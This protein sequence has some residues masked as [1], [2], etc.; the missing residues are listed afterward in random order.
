MSLPGFSAEYG[1]YESTHYYQ[2]SAPAERNIQ[3]SWQVSQPA[4][5]V[6]AW[7]GYCEQ[8]DIAGVV[9]PATCRKIC[10]TEGTECSV[11]CSTGSGGGSVPHCNPA[12]PQ[13]TPQNPNAN[14]VCCGSS[15]YIN[16]VLT[17][18]ESCTNLLTD[19]DNCGACNAPCIVD[20]GYGGH[21]VGDC[22]GGACKDIFTDNNN[23]GGCGI[24]CP[25]GC[26]NG[27]CPGS[28]GP[29]C[30][31][32]TTMCNGSCVNTMNDPNNCGGC[33]G[34]QNYQYIC[35]P[36]NT[37]VNGQC[38]YPLTNGSYNCP[39]D[40]S[41]YSGGNIHICCG[42]GQYGVGCPD[43]NGIITSMSCI[44][45]CIAV[46]CDPPPPTYTNT[47][48]SEDICCPSGECAKSC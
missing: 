27:T 13:K 42:A 30:Q 23:C 1:L 21:A 32:G 29:T 41:P 6:P 38:S 11:V 15:E 48:T 10:N 14:N 45:T 35:S 25:T 9:V 40:Y 44:P 33:G 18:V 7:S 43:D 47:C 46:T 12:C 17:P 16:G 3:G 28:T 31:D 8:S 39:L 26:Q 37:C 34:G 4:H 36:P 20:D 22:C 5:V 2:S 19:R 24:E